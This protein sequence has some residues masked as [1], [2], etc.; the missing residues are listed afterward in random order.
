MPRRNV[1]NTQQKLF[2]GFSPDFPCYLLQGC[3]CF[4]NVALNTLLIPLQFQLWLK[5]KKGEKLPQR[6]NL[7]CSF[8]VT[9]CFMSASATALQW[10][11]MFSVPKQTYLLKL[12]L[13]GESGICNDFICVIDLGL[14]YD[15]KRS[16]DEEGIKPGLTQSH[17]R[18]T[19]WD[20]W[21][22]CAG[23]GAPLDNPAQDTLWSHENW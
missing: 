22:V 9:L 19:G 13:F 7:T 16:C 18:G 11:W 10:A 14:E 1:K 20:W 21:G 15:S 3:G 2:F 8:C 4:R 23:P 6:K 5:C 17:L 12:T